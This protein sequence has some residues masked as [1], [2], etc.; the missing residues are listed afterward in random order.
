MPPPS[1]AAPRIPTRWFLALGAG[2]WV[3]I[4]PACVYV[5]RLLHLLQQRTDPVM[6]QLRAGSACVTDAR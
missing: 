4:L 6:P 5:P 3:F 1:V 2:Y